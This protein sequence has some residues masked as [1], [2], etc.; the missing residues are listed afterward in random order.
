[1]IINFGD[2]KIYKKVIRETWEE[3]R[4]CLANKYFTYNDIQSALNT[5]F[6]HVFD[7]LFEHGYLFLEKPICTA[8]NSDINLVRAA[9]IN[10]NDPL[11]NYDRFIPDAKYITKANRFSPPCVEWLYLAFSDNKEEDGL[12]L[13]EKCA[14]RECCAN[15]GDTFAL[16]HFLPSDAYKDKKIIDLTIAKEVNFATIN[17]ELENYGKA[18]LQRESQKVY[19]E[20][21]K[22]GILIKPNLDDMIIPITK[23]AVYT[24]ARLLSEQIFLPLT[25]EDRDIIYAPFQ[26]M[27]QY[28]FQKGYIGIIYSSTVFPE[29]KNIVLFDKNAAIPYGEIKR[30]TV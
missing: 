23:W 20:S 17:N 27:A 29:G 12:P 1:M 9:R 5:R 4:N 6:L 28:F 16:C 10:S 3:F 8:L 25:T 13:E 19:M 24:Y 11:P 30:I 7:D 22:K 2:E 18:V 26:C 21:I 14:L 15:E